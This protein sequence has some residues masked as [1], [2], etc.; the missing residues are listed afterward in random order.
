LVV[1][2]G[3]LIGKNPWQILDR[4][5]RAYQPP[6]IFPFGLDQYI[7]KG[8]K[9]PLLRRRGRQPQ[10]IY[11][12]RRFAGVLADDDRARFSSI[13]DLARDVKLPGYY[14]GIRLIKATIKGF[15][16]YFQ[17]Q[18]INLHERNFSVRYATS[19]PRQVGLAG[20]SA[21][22]GAYRDEAMFELLRNALSQIGAQVIKPQVN[23]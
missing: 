21:I 7:L 15:V 18:A 22:I 10:R 11:H 12:D 3:R 19:I 23:P 20:S 13:Y 14:G 1:A 4:Y 5:H 8:Q 2:V 17:A 9:A 6:G 16:D